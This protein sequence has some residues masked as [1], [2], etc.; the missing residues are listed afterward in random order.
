MLKNILTLMLA[1]VLS[2]TTGGSVQDEKMTTGVS[3]LRRF[4]AFTGG[5]AG[6][7]DAPERRIRRAIRSEKAGKW[8]N[9]FHPARRGAFWDSGLRW[10]RYNRW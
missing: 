8:L 9:S 7:T 6:E 1:I 4:P 10:A 5:W 2:F 3:R